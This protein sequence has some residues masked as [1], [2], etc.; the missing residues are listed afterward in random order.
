MELSN[1]LRS[2]AVLALTSFDLQITR[3]TAA[4]RVIFKQADGGRLTLDKGARLV[5][6]H[7]INIC[8]I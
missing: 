8:G 1:E 6:F 7:V 3:H 4:T 2:Q 5:V